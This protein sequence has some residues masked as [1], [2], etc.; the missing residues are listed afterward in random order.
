MLQDEKVFL[1]G[2]IS[3]QILRHAVEKEENHKH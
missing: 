3:R 1:V 2:A